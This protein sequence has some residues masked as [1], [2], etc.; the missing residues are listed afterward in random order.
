MGFV[1][2]SASLFFIYVSANFL[3]QAHSKKKKYV[4][5]INTI[6]DEYIKQDL[7]FIWEFENDFLG[8]RDFQYEMKVKWPS[9]SHFDVKEKTLYLFLRHRDDFVYSLSEEEIGTEK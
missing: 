7:L 5:K 4:E 1:F 6:S 3:I 2:L 8:Y 9:F